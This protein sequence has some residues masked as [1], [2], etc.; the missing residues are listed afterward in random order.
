M[1]FTSGIVVNIL[2]QFSDIEVGG[3]LPVPTLF[4][5]VLVLWDSKGYDFYS[6]DLVHILSLI[7]VVII[8]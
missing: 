2:C 4:T 1:L 7:F 5:Y 6:V 8:S 3:A